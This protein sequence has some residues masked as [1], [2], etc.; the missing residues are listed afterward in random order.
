M[1][2]GIVRLRLLQLLA[3]S[4]SYSPSTS[5][6]PHHK[7][8]RA[9]RLTLPPRASAGDQQR[10]LGAW[11]SKVV[12]N[13]NE[14]DVGARGEQWFFGQL[15][16][17]VLVLV[18][19]SLNLSPPTRAAGLLL[20]AASGAFAATSA[21]ALGDSLSPWTKPVGDNELKT[22]GP[23]ELCRHPIYTGLVG[24][25]TGLGLAT[26]STERLLATVL[27]LAFLSQKAQGEER[28]LSLIHI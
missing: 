28:Q 6:L 27:L 3:T 21:F 12:A 26:L 5:I 24:V 14:G 9:L 19:P 1:R 22:D 8:I 17:V 7:T 23:F 25:C 11:A 18:A 15:A 20:F 13:I 2:L 16:L 10:D 4:F